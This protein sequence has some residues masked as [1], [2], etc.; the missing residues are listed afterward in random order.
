MERNLMERN[1]IEHNLLDD[2]LVL[3]RRG[4]PVIDVGKGIVSGRRKPKNI[5]F[6]HF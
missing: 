5:F 1:L 2:I 6:I 3:S 4:D